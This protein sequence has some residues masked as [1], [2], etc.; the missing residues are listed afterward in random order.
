MRTSNERGFSVVE[1]LIIVA[2][3]SLLGFVAY[4]FSNRM[5]DTSEANDQ[6]A[7]ATVQ[8]KDVPEVQS[9][10]DLDEAQSTLDEVSIDDDTSSLDADMAEF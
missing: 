2:V 10:K 4:S 1:L 8:P 5:S 3:L 7:S 6:A 9:A